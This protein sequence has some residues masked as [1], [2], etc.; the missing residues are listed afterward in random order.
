[1][2]KPQRQT[3]LLCARRA[4]VREAEVCLQIL[5]GKPRGICFF[6]DSTLARKRARPQRRGWGRNLGMAALGRRPWGSSRP[7]SSPC[8]SRLGCGQAPGTVSGRLSPVSPAPSCTGE[9][10]DPFPPLAVLCRTWTGGRWPPSPRGP[11]AGLWSVS[12]GTPAAVS[13]QLLWGG[14][15]PKAV[16]ELESSCRPGAAA[17]D[18]VAESRC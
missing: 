18:L 7:G 16:L 12:T 6:K 5:P 17:A 9:P 15:G 4:A 3:H 10:M 1:M 11:V 2:T 13:A 8:W 14:F